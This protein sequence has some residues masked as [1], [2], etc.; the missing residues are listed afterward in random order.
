MNSNGFPAAAFE[1]R[2]SRQVDP[3]CLQT[4]VERTEGRCSAGDGVEE[5]AGLHDERVVTGSRFVRLVVPGLVGF[6]HPAPTLGVRF[7][8]HRAPFANDCE[9]DFVVLDAD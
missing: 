7:P 4:F 2:E 1:T 5:T 3:Q 6:G 8:S 9:R